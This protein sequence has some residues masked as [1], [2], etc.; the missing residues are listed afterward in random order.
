MFQVMFRLVVAFSLLLQ[1][2]LH[3]VAQDVIAEEDEGVLVLTKV[4]CYRVSLSNND[5]GL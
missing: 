2:A 4:N 1:F 3:P 5:R